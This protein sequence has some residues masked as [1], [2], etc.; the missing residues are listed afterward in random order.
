MLCLVHSSLPWGGREQTKQDCLH[1]RSTLAVMEK[2]A[3][4]LALLLLAPC[5]SFRLVPS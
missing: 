1:Q 2:A 3:I 4:S 5:C